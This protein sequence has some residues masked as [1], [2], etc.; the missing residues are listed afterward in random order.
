MALQFLL[1]LVGDI[2]DPLYTIERNDGAGQC[3]AALPPGAKTPVRL[4][5]YWDDTLVAA[6][7]GKDPVKAAA[8]MAAAL[9]PGEIQRWSGGAPEQW[10]QES[11]ELAKTTV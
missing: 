8:Q 9:P 4:S 1:N 7:A 2:H 3:V 11:Y 10:A 5:T 6:A